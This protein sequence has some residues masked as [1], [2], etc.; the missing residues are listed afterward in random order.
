MKRVTSN[1]PNI[2]D[3]QYT[4]LKIIMVSD[5]DDDIGYSTSFK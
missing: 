4:N 3:I 1:M 5:P 2:P